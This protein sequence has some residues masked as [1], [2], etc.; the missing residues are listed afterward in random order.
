MSG[1]YGVDTDELKRLT[2][3]MAEVEPRAEAAITAMNAEV[4]GLHATF[5]GETATA[6]A[7]AHAKWAKTKWAKT[8]SIRD[9]GFEATFE[10]N[11]QQVWSPRTIPV[12]FRR[13]CPFLENERDQNLS[14]SSLE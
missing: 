4:D 2:E 14:C 6:H 13:E 7:A 5:T 10:K 8:M 1:E 9:F 3:R 11:D 12:P